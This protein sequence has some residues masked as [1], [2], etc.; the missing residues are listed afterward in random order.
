MIT[1]FILKVIFAVDG[2]N[3]YTLTIRRKCYIFT[4]NKECKALYFVTNMVL[5]KWGGRGGER[6][7]ERERE[8]EGYV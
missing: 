7:R 2:S 1:N 4:I 5:K 6:E 8:R 3:R